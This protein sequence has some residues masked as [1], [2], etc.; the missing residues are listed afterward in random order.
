[1]HVT[2]RVPPDDRERASQDRRITPRLLVVEFFDELVFTLL[3]LSV[4]LLR[5]AFDL[6]YAQIGLLLGLPLVV[7]TVVEPIVL[8]LGDTRLRTRLIL[9]G[10]LVLGASLALTAGAGTFGMLLIALALAGPASAAFV[11]LSQVEL[12]QRSPGGE[13]QIMARWTAS[14]TVGD[15]VAAPL[16][17]AA[18]VFGGSWRTVLFVLGAAAVLLTGSLARPLA[19]RRGDEGEVKASPRLLLENLR[20][21]AGRRRLWRWLLLLPMSDLMLDVFFGYLAVYLADEVGL[22]P[23]AAALGG[24]VWLAGFLAGQLALVRLLP[25]WDGLRLSRWTAGLTLVVFPIWLVAADGLAWRLGT[26]AILGLLAAPWYPALQGAAYAEAPDRPATVAALNSVV[27]SAA[28]VLAALVGVA[29]AHL[30][31]AG[32]LLLLIAGPLAI[33]LFA[34]SDAPS[35]KVIKPSGYN[36][37]ERP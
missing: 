37:P 6:D 22:S 33:V 11:S 14:G 1:M 4:P 15:L 35:E 12:I 20:R 23:A 7:G 5:D 18:I 28:G 9:G 8:L 30:G 24:S 17:A 2:L 3:A 10:G 16:L 31:L 26:L 27:G 29:A 32:G 36:S 25:R 19:G 34:G 13:T 21:L